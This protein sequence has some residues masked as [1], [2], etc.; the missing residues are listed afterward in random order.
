[1]CHWV[2]LGIC[3]MGLVQPEVVMGLGFVEVGA[4]REMAATSHQPL[5]PGP[6]SPVLWAALHLKEGEEG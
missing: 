1:M 6:F 4:E 5:S 3:K 2:F